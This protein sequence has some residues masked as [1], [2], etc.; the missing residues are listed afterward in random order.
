MAV[1]LAAGQEA[2]LAEVRRL[3]L[4]GIK[5]AKDRREADAEALYW[6]ALRLHEQILGTE[7]P[8]VAESLNQI[9]FFCGIHKSRVEAEPLI[10]RSLALVRQNPG[11]KKR[12]VLQTLDMLAIRA[13]HLGH[14]E[15]AEWYYKQVL[16]AREEF[17]EPN[18]PRMAATLEGYAALLREMGRGA[19]AETLT[20]RAKAIR[21][22]RYNGEGEPK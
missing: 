15:E 16:T 13:Q 14:Y 12:S 2:Q 21:Q 11:P 1:I 6:Q 3:R 10:Q 9:I 20:R 17:L 19:E 22:V 8:R 18:H 5:A 4:E 7:D